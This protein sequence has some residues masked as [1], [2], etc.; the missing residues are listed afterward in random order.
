MHIP[1]LD[2]EKHRSEVWLNVVRIVGIVLGI[3]AYVAMVW[4]RI[5]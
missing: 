5:R 3:I 1:D 4:W 2:G